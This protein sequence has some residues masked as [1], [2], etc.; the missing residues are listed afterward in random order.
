LPNN[1]LTTFKMKEI[2]NEMADNMT[3]DRGMEEIKKAE[4]ENALKENQENVYGSMKTDKE[5]RNIA[6][7]MRIRNNSKK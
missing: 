4:K 6:K 7:G 5:N 1:Y 3:T 2:K